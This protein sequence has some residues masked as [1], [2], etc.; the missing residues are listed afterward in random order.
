MSRDRSPIRTGIAIRMADEG[1]PFRA[2]QR[3]LQMPEDELRDDLE[4]A[5]YHGKLEAVPVF[6]WPR[7][8]TRLNRRP[9]SAPI[10]S[11]EF[12]YS[13][14]SSTFGL[15][16]DQSVL[17]EQLLRHEVCTKGLLYAALATEGDPKIVDVHLC[18]IR[19]RVANH[20]EIEIH[21]IWGIGYS[22]PRV[23]ASYAKRLIQS[24]FEILVTESDDAQVS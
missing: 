14:I 10:F 21:T 23:S 7:D 13:M 12:S 4:L 8:S 3:V 24:R 17:F 9:L 6:D 16:R 5:V 18:N 2:I 1:I 19:K 11:S 22:M 15:T 20:K